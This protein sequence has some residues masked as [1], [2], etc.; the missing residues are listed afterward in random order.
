MFGLCR[1]GMA[2]TLRDFTVVKERDRV[3]AGRLLIYRGEPEE[4]VAF[5]SPEAVLAFVLL[6]MGTRNIN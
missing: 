1:V 6:K 2:L 3:Q 5:A 4:Y